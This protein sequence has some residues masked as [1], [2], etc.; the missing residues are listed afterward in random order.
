MACSK[1]EYLKLDI[2]D[3][4][5]YAKPSYTDHIINL[6][7]DLPDWV[8]VKPV[9]SATKRMEGRYREIN[10]LRNEKENYTEE[11]I[12]KLK[13]RIEEKF[14]INY[15]GRAF[16]ADTKIVVEVPQYI[17]GPWSLFVF[18]HEVAHIVLD[19]VYD[20]FSDYN[21]WREEH[22]RK[23]GEHEKQANEWAMEKLKTWKIPITKRIENHCEKTIL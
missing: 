1:N 22:K 9:P 13:E 18:A 19:H 21:A 11:E 5:F 14:D 3:H 16:F 17:C 6:L 2:H 15:A 4:T 23:E 10:S 20:G 7:C 12:K 8:L